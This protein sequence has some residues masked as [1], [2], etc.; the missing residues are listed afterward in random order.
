[1]GAAPPLPRGGILGDEMGLGKTVTMLALFLVRRRPVVELAAA[2]FPEALQWRAGV[3]RP[4][5]A[6]VS[7]GG[8]GG[9]RRSQ[10]V[11]LIELGA[12]E[13]EVVVPPQPV[14]ATLVVAPQTLVAQWH[15][16]LG[17]HAPTLRVLTYRGMDGATWARSFAG[18]D[19]VLTSYEV[20]RR[21]LPRGPRQEKWA[22]PLLHVQWWRVAL[23]EAQTVSSG[24]S[25]T[26]RM[27]AL[28]ER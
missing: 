18:A 25:N 10:R 5:G 21:E 7:G 19:V 2:T 26:A 13:R 28:L 22:S 24:T 27:C 20:L 8:G 6:G 11:A 1:M 4:T 23:D 16:E 15:S 17:R 14:G 12:D 9:A 3:P